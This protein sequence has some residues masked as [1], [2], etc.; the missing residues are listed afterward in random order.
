[1]SWRYNNVDRAILCKKSLEI[2]CSAYPDFLSLNLSSPFVMVGNEISETQ[3]P[4][5]CDRVFE[6]QSLPL[7]PTFLSL[8]CHVLSSKA[9][10][11]PRK[12]H[13]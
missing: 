9:Q 7:P 12:L 5:L 10:Y 8:H 3:D 1:M 4:T 11:Q 13:I 2:Y 6:R